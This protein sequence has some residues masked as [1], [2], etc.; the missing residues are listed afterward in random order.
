MSAYLLRKPRAETVLGGWREQTRRRL[1]PSARPLLD[2]VPASGS[3]PDFLTPPCGGT[4]SEGIDTLLSTPRSRLAA[5]F[6]HLAQERPLPSWTVDLAEGRP[7]ALRMVGH[8]L[9]EYFHTCLAPHWDAIAA[10]VRHD[11]TRRAQLMADQGVEAVLNTLSPAAT[12]RFPLLSID[13]LFDHDVRLDGRGLLLQPV[14][15]GRGPN[16]TTLIDPAL[17]PVLV[18]SVPLA[19]GAITPVEPARR[20]AGDPIVPLLG[21]TRTRILRALDNTNATTTELARRAATPLPT[22]SRHA[23][24]LRDANL[25]TSHRHKNMMIHTITPLGTALLHGRQPRLN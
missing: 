4:L 5:D 15:F 20:P 21:T 19:L 9:R 3:S 22:A 2:L 6:A 17:P 10:A 12:W 1:T 14:V 13:Y 8:A 24:A 23:T 7:P 18:Y 11:H 25:I 16:P